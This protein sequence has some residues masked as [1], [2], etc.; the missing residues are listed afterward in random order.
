MQ[1][2]RP[3]NRE[4]MDPLSTVLTMKMRTA[5]S[6]RSPA[7]VDNRP[8]VRSRYVVKTASRRAV[9]MLHIVSEER[10]YS[11]GFGRHDR[12]AASTP[13]SH[14]TTELAPLLNPLD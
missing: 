4:L 1:H 5:A 6:V 10:S 14:Q 13:Q 7:L 12:V 2:G 8:L 3:S 9:Q 11:I